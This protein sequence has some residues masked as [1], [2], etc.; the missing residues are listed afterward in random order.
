MQLPEPKR[1]ELLSTRS[2]DSTFYGIKTEWQEEYKK[3]YGSA[4]KSA[5]SLLSNAKKYCKT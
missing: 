2:G 3:R 5:S 1:T 4:P